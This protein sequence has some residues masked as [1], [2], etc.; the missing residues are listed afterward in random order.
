MTTSRTVR[1]LSTALL[2]ASVSGCAGPAEEDDA[3]AGGST[4]TSSQ[5]PISPRISL[6]PPPT[7][8][9]TIDG[10][11]IG[12]AVAV[13][14]SYTVT[15]TAVSLDAAAAVAAVA[16][17]ASAPLGRFVLVDLTATP[18]EGGAGGTAAP[19]DLRVQLADEF[20][21]YG[22]C[23]NADD[24]IARGLRT[25][26]PGGAVSWQVC[27]DVPPTAAVPTSVVVVSDTTAAQVGGDPVRWS[28]D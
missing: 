7:P 26:G 15:V 22:Q 6:A 23:E 19:F 28:L 17:E 12:E 2:V 13:D 11:P 21:T 4:S 14:Y 9:A 27:L 5:A 3:D 20:G 16:P 18:T 24:V 25:S 10:F 1:V 8:T